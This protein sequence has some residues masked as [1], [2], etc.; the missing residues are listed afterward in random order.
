MHCFPFNPLN[1][2][3]NFI[4]RLLALLGAHHILHISRIRVNLH[5]NQPAEHHLIVP[6]SPA[7]P[8]H[9]LP[10]VQPQP[11]RL[12]LRF[13]SVCSTG[14]LHIGIQVFYCV[15]NYG[16][17]QGPQLHPNPLQISP[18]WLTI[19]VQH[20]PTWLTDAHISACLP[21]KCSYWNSIT[22]KVKMTL[23]CET[24]DKH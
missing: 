9:H 4:C 6:W 5:L 14:L 21:L 7:A 1:T 8:A 19:L 11:F 16:P 17:S 3:L 23:P 22:L 10:T 12:A 2:K 24:S 15:H 18:H 13:P 20:S